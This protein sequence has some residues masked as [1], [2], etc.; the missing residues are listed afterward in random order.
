M[1]G[2]GHSVITIHAI[3]TGRVRIKKN[4]A[5]R[6]AGAWPSEAYVIL[7]SE[8]AEW[9]PIYAWAIEHPDGVIVV[10]AG[11]VAR[12]SEPGYFPPWHPY[13]RFAVQFDVKPEDEIGPQLKQRGINPSDVKTVIFTHLHT[14]HIGGIHHFPDSRILIHPGDYRLAQ[15]FAGK[16]RGYLPHRMPSWLKPDP[17]VFN[18][19]VVEPFGPTHEVTGDGFVKIISTPGHTPNHVSVLVRE[20][21][22]SYI[23]AGDAAYSQKNLAEGRIDGISA[24]KAAQQSIDNLRAYCRDNPTIFLPC[25]DPDAA[26]RLEK[27]KVAEV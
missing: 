7:G 20:N 16:V 5:R 23:I 22:L 6:R 17:I 8:W 4:Q 25:H 26:N 10:D 15:G 11:E 21:G 3:Q 14:D 18:G 13:F 24:A 1:H 9:L 27:N 12:T 2:K 19:S